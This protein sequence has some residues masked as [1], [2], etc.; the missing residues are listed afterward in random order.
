LQVGS[1][2]ITPL[3]TAPEKDT[4]DVQNY[5]YYANEELAAG[6]QPLPYGEYKQTSA[7]AGATSIDFNQNQ[8][9]AAGFAD[10]TVSA[11]SILSDP[12]IVAAQTDIRE[13]GKSAI[14]GVGNYVIS[15]EKQMA[16]QAERDFVNAILRRE[17]G[18]VISPSEFENA[19]RQYF[20]QPGDSE[21]VIAQKARNRDVAIKG[22]VRAAGQN[23]EAP[24]LTPPNADQIIDWTQL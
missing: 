24:S 17:S 8:G 23:Y 20:P 21:E 7:R 22:L 15:K 13:A 12:K 3:Y 19:R 18:A 16:E 5:K 1:D 9:V 2:G 14:P 6:R 4:G 11:N 10:R